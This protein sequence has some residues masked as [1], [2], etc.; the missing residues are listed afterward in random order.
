MSCIPNSAPPSPE[1]E[2][3]CRS[4]RERIEEK[5][6]AEHDRKGHEIEE[7]EPEV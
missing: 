6:V 1:R 5:D 7:K 3:F 2:Y 4:C